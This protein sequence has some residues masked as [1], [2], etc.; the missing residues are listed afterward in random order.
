[1][2]DNVTKCTLL[3][4]LINMMMERYP[5]CTDLHCELN[6]V[7]RVAKVNVGLSVCVLVFCGHLSMCLC[8]Y[9]VC[10]SLSIC[11]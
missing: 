10:V 1:M 6:G 2:K 9:Y 11:V 3:E 7:H 4:H 5:D 8:V